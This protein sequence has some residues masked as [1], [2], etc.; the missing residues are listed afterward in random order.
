MNITGVTSSFQLPISLFLLIA[1]LFALAGTN[2]QARLAREQ[3]FGDVDPL[4]AAAGRLWSPGRWLTRRSRRRQRDA[5]EGEL[6]SDP[7]RWR[8]YR[9]LQDDLF[10]WNA[11]ESSVAVA[12]A[13]ALLALVASLLN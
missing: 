2:T 5:A 6:R 7:A 13:G 1:A 9:R 3:L 4:V 10:A 11:L 8:H 12:A